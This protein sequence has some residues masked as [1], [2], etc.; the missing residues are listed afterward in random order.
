MGISSL[1]LTHPR[2]RRQGLIASA[3]ATERGGTASTAFASTAPWAARRR[4]DL[5]HLLALLDRHIGA[6]SM[7]GGT[8]F[9]PDVIPSE[10]SRVLVL[11]LAGS[12]TCFR[13][14]TIFVYL[15]NAFV[16]IEG[17]PL[18]GLVKKLLRAN[19]GRQPV[20]RN[21]GCATRPIP[22]EALPLD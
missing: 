19:S 9:H 2:K 3:K 6:E 8:R 17:H 18:R 10:C 4:E 11:N 14:A 12:F 7:V 15:D 1:F 22:C 13:H 5:F 21:Q 20:T 16:L